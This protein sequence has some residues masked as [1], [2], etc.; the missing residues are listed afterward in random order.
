MNNEILNNTDIPL[1]ESFILI[2]S[3]LDGLVVRDDKISVGASL[4]IANK[5]GKILLNAPDLFEG[6]DVLHANYLKMTIPTGEPM[7]WEEKYDAVDTF[8]D[9]YGT[10]KIEN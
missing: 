5:N 8:W 1:G 6:K 10:G 4:T 2:N 7:A 9:K 3:D